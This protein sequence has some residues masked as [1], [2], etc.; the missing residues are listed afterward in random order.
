MSKEDYLCRKVEAFK[1]EDGASAS[2]LLEKME[3]TAFQGK[4]L[5]LAARVWE[6]A[7]KEDVTILMGLSGA[8]VPAGMRG[9]VEFAIENRMID[10]LVSTGAN[11]FHDAHE[12]LGLHHYQGSANVDD[13]KLLEHK[14]DR[15]YDVFAS[16]DEFLEVDAK[17]REFSGDLEKRYTT[18]EFLYRLGLYLE[19]E[20]KADTILTKAAKNKFPIFCPA[21]CDSAIGLALA[22]DMAIAGK[23]VE[24][25]TIRDVVE[26]TGV[27]SKAKDT[28]VIYLG[29]GIPKNYIQQ[30]EVAYTHMN[31]E[32]KGHKYAIQVTTDNPVFG[33]LSGCTFDEAQSWGKIAVDAEKV[34]VFCDTTIALPLIASAVYERSMDILEKRESPENGLNWNF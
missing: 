19:K 5:A 28:G 9:L 24:I 8:M 26:L 31:E 25:D 3:K 18:R 13:S 11:L 17:I 29:G 27:V 12:A 16:E 22:E 15:I 21:L 4:N 14:I 6:K 30:T 7:L 20:G 1:I 23:K 10:V 33:G 32:I 2:R 34:M